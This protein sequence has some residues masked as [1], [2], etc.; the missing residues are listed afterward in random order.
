M[1]LKRAKVGEIISLVKMVS[2]EKPPHF[3]KLTNKEA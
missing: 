2:L 3:I 1:V